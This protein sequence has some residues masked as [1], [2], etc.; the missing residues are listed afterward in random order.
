MPDEDLDDERELYHADTWRW[1]T[2]QAGALRQRD[3]D[4]IDWENVIR[5]IAKLAGYERVDWVSY[6]TI[7]IE[8]YHASAK[9][10][11]RWRARAHRERLDLHHVD[12]H[13]PALAARH[14]DEML[15]ES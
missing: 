7:V 4:A 2:E 15:A 12:W 3:L 13:N 10:I 5:E 8:H 11:S 14:R 1:S 6:C 9:K